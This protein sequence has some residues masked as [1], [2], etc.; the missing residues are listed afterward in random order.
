MANELA[1]ITANNIL[2]QDA[3]SIFCTIPA[4]PGDR[5]ASAKVFQALNN[6]EYRVADFIN[7]KI[8]V[9]NVLIEAADIMDDETGEVDRVPR[10]VLISPEGKSYQAVSL[11]MYGAVKNAFLCFGPAPW[12]PA[13]TFL[14]K[15]KPV[16]NGSMLTA[17]VY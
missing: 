14:I 12:N 15:Q 7:K 4:Q 8:Q 11:G 17:D 1:T 13:L 6:P 2:A 3:G 10:V 9:S 5:E 16:K